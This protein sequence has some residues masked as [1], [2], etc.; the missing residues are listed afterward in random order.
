MLHVTLPITHLYSIHPK[1]AEVIDVLLGGLSETTGLTGESCVKNTRAAPSQYL[2]KPSVFGCRFQAVMYSPRTL[3]RT[4]E[5]VPH[6]SYRLTTA[7]EVMQ[8]P[9]K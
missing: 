5:Y 3:T 2:N 6:I 7:S 4:V 1:S 9:R 8:L